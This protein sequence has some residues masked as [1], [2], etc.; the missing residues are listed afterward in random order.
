[1]SQKTFRV[2]VCLLTGITLLSLILHLLLLP[3]AHLV[4]ILF[5]IQSMPPVF[6]GLLTFGAYQVLSSPEA[7]ASKSL[8][9]HLLLR[10]LLLTCLSIFFLHLF[11]FLNIHFFHLTP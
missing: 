9:L 5:L 11:L 2:C 3:F 1:M 8:T 7:S 6:E 10:I 4:M